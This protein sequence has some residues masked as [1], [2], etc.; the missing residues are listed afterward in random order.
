LEFGVN[1]GSATIH[2][3]ENDSILDLDPI[4]IEE[5]EK[6][7][8]SKSNVECRLGV[9]ADYGLFWLPYSGT[10]LWLD[11]S[12]IMQVEN[13]NMSHPLNSTINNKNWAQNF[14]VGL[15]LTVMFSLQRSSRE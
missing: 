7:K 8:E 2:H 9:Y 10:N 3:V 12:D 15:K 11:N 14:F 6:E 1:L 5:K 4:E 13:W